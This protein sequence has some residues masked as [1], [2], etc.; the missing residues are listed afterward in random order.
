MKQRYAGRVAGGNYEVLDPAGG[1]VKQM[2]LA[3][4]RTDSKLKAAIER[5]GWD[6]IPEE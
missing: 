5:N 3:A 1:V 6:A 4:A 2:T